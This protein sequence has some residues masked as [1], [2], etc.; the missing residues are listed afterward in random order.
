MALCLNEVFRWKFM[1]TDPNWSNFLFGN[2]NN[3]PRLIL[4]DFGA[5]RAYSTQFI[6]KYMRILKAA[7]NNNREEVI[8]MGD[9]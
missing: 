6:D 2:I 1:Q 5:T 8:F 9:K 4:L 7:F 3:N